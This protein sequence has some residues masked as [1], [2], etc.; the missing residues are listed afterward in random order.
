VFLGSGAGA[1]DDE[2]DNKNVGIGID[3]L[4]KIQSEMKILL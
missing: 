1:V 3:A 2:S 4:N